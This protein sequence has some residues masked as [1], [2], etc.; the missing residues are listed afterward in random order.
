MA[1][2][3]PLGWTPAPDG[4]GIAPTF[5]IG[6]SA[7]MALFSLIGGPTAVFF[8]APIMG[9][10]TLLLVYRLARE[11]FDAETALFAAALVAWNP[12]FI[13]YA[14]Q[15][16]SD[17]AATMW[18]MLALLL[19]VRSSNASAFARDLAAGAA[20]VTRPA[21]LVAAARD[22]ARRASRRVARRASWR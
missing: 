10:I 12:L 20:V 8:V 3:S 18:I 5:P 14:K 7:V 21:L 6:V 2:A 4:S 15:P 9:L 1:L 13:T 17:M 22:S 16:M 11:W 19:A